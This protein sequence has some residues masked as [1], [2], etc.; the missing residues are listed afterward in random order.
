MGWMNKKSSVVL[1]KSM[2]K[3]KRMKRELC[4]A[5][6]IEIALA[7]EIGLPHSRT[8][9]KYTNVRPPAY[10]QMNMPFSARKKPTP[11][12]IVIVMR[13]ANNMADLLI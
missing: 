2:P 13:I 6:S 1:T 9:A 10:Q 8:S 4:A 5:C 3:T 7:L 11:I 12:R